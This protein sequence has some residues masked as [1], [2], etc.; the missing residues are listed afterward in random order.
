MKNL[1]KIKPD[2]ERARS[3]IRLAKF[4]YE[5]IKTFDEEKECSLIIHKLIEKLFN[6]C[7]KK[8]IWKQNA[9]ITLSLQILFFAARHCSGN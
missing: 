4:R 5:K 6:T 1:I 7:D 2:K 3:L 8:L 9:T